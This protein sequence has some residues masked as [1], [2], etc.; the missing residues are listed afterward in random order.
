MYTYQ[1]VVRDIY[2]TNDHK[3]T[4]PYPIIGTDY[5]Y[6]FEE[7][8]LVAF[9]YKGYWAGIG[10]YSHEPYLVDRK[11]FHIRVLGDEG[12]NLALD[13]YLHQHHYDVFEN[14]VMKFGS[15]FSCANEHYL[16]FSY[17]PGANDESQCG[18]KTIQQKYPLV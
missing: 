18:P 12:R 16:L 5:F 2:P 17:H 4:G 10:V 8:R 9:D 6:C 14:G 11:W 13:A 3:G 15:P 7:G 1:L